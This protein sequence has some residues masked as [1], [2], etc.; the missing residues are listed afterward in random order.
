ME[1]EG[2]LDLPEGVILLSFPQNRIRAM[3]GT[4]SCA[5]EDYF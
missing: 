4:I 1:S 3:K 5:T 2:V